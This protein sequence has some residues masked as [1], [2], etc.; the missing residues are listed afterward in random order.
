MER[1]TDSERNLK[2]DRQRKKERQSKREKWKERNTMK[3][4][5]RNIGRLKDRKYTI[6]QKEGYRKK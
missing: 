1:N 5:G 2:K 4:I 6:S 3:E